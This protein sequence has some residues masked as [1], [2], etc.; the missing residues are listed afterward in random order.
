MASSAQRM[1]GHSD[2]YGCSTVPG[3]EHSTGSSPGLAWKL[4]RFG[5][6][7]SCLFLKTHEKIIT[8]KQKKQKPNPNPNWYLPYQ[9]SSV[10]FCLE[11]LNSGY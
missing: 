8:K 10:G 2:H 6:V 7:P 9:S 1:N 3:A 4:G 5:R 11:L